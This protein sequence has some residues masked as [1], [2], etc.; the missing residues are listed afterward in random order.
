MK[1]VVEIDKGVG[2]P[3]LRPKFFPSHEIAGALQ[4]SREH[5]QGLALQAQLDPVFPQLARADIQ[6]KTVESQHAHRWSHCG[7]TNFRK[8]GK[9]YHS[10]CPTE[11]CLH[12]PRSTSFSLGWRWRKLWEQMGT[13][14][15]DACAITGEGC[16][17]FCARDAAT[18]LYIISP[19]RF[20]ER[21][22][23]QEEGEQDEN[24][25]NFG[26]RPDTQFSVGSV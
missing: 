6:L 10:S 12:V 25:N 7:H 26:R 22:P 21:I 3:D 15:I 1:A 19:R 13:E 17:C 23:E 2:W 8:F 5:L 20:P 16:R 9:V 11:T 18:A 14:R 24:P 4:Q